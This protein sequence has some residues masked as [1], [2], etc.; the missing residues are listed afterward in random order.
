MK[1]NGGNIMVKEAHFK[2]Y[3]AESQQT[4]I[5]VPQISAHVEFQGVDYVPYKLS[6]QPSN[7][8]VPQEVR[9]KGTDSDAGNLGHDWYEALGGVHQEIQ[10]RYG[11][12]W[13]DVSLILSPMAKTV[14]LFNSY[15][16]LE[17]DQIDLMKEFLTSA[18]YNVR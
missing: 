13:K 15:V 11:E 2:L 17:Q 6:S 8:S 5:P 16:P 9:F 4:G 10:R 1:R 7:P 3:W 12:D 14:G 18:G